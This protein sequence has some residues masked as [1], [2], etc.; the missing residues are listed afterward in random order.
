MITREVEIQQVERATFKR[1]FI[2]ADLNWVSIMIKVYKE[3]QEL[4]LCNNV[5]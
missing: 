3:D 5:L 2:K 4:F 1:I